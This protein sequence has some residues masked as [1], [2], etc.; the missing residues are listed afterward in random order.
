MVLNIN[1]YFDDKEYYYTDNKIIFTHFSANEGDLNW[2][3]YSDYQKRYLVLLKLFQ[4][5]YRDEIKNIYIYHDTRLIEEM[6]GVLPPLNH[7]GKGIVRYI[8]R[9]VLSS[10]AEVRRAASKYSQKCYPIFY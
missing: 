7:W 8:A 4:D 2:K 6:K 5:L 1:C 3:W 9:N 10:A